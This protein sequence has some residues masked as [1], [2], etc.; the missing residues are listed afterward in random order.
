MKKRIAILIFIAMIFSFSACESTSKN[1]RKVTYDQK[2]SSEKTSDIEENKNNNLFEIPNKN[3]ESPEEIDNR[4]ANVMIDQGY[5]L[6]HASQIQEILNTIGINEI[7]IENTTGESESG[8]NS[9]ICYPNGYTD[10][11]RRF[12][13]TTD[14]GVLFY[15]GFGSEDLYVIEEGGYLKNYNDVHVPEKEVSIDVF[16]KLQLLAEESVKGCL[17]YPDTANF[18]M[19]S[20]R[21]ARSDNMYQ[22]LGEV[23]A[24][25]G[26]GV[27]DDISFSVW[28]IDNNGTYSIEAISLDGVRV[29]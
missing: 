2:I 21:I 15:A 8:L 19:F 18:S 6:E 13:F 23:N 1:D 20:W 25:N 24:S 9:I 26:F 7:V 28:F 14:N 10:R 12:Y 4:I 11:D 16:S 17:N 5:S 27:K 3:L 22:I 29:K